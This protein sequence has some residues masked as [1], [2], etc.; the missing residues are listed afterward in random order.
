[1]TSMFAEAFRG[2]QQNLRTLA[3]YVALIVS[4]HSGLLIAN[5]EFIEPV[6]ETLDP[7]H[8]NLYKFSTT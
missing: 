2:L 8:L 1:M 6:K 4:L 3:L 5:L 7:L